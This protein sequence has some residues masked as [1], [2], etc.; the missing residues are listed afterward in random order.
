[1]LQL[2]R[3]ARPTSERHSC[4]QGGPMR[5][6]H[7]RAIVCLGLTL[8]L[9]IPAFAD[10]PRLDP[11]VAPTSQSVELNLDADK[12]TYTG[13]VKIQLHV[14]KATREFLFHAE[15]MTLDKVELTGTGGAI[16]ITIA[17]GGDRGTQKATT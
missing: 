10:E 12:D 11:N 7:F 13:S 17:S 3:R 1:M 5:P 4:F 9:A 6:R 15:E 2:R 8:A 14:A 16:P